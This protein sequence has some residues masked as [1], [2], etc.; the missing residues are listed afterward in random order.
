MRSCKRVGITGVEHGVVDDEVDSAKEFGEA[1]SAVD[2]LVE[3]ESVE[4]SPCLREPG[5]YAP[6][7]ASI[8]VVDAES[9]VEDDE[10]RWDHLFERVGVTCRPEGIAVE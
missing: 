5:G 2:D 9:A 8:K 7:R 10:N 6:N 4:Q 1:T 3:N